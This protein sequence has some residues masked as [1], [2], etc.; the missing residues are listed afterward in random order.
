MAK[1]FSK[2][3]NDYNKLR[4]SGNSLVPPIPVLDTIFYDCEEILSEKVEELEKC[5]LDSGTDIDFKDY[6]D[7]KKDTYFEV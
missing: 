6:L 2:L 7:F 5:L 1:I 4:E 3:R